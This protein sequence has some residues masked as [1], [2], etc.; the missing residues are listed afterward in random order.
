V[1]IY[2]SHLE[3]VRDFS[4]QHPSHHLIEINVDDS[5]NAGTI[6]AKSFGLDETCWKFDAEALDNDWQDF[7]F[8]L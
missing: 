6:L 7:S 8:Q 4:R 3:R 5:S 1:E 2:E